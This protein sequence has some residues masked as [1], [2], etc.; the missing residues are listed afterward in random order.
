MIQFDEHIF[1][2]GWFNHQLGKIRAIFQETP[3]IER[4]DTKNAKPPFPRPV[5]LGIHV[6][7]RGV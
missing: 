5:I 3:E 2:T 7:F 1:Q 6:S 4:I